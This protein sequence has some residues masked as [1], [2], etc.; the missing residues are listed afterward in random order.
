MKR[1]GE[2]WIYEL[3]TTRV[4]DTPEAVTEVP[5]GATLPPVLKSV[6]LR[7]RVTNESEGFTPHTALFP[8]APTQR[9]ARHIRELA[10]LAKSG[11]QAA[12]IFCVSRPDAEAVSPFRSRDPQFA[13]AVEEAAQAGV[14]FR[15]VRFRYTL[16]GAI[17]HG[18][19]PVVL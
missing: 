15:A 17:F 13:Q 14:V 1:L 6:S 7:D 11:R 4:K 2:V 16:D 19:I 12:V 5:E 3:G 18:P 10:E 9:G 8:D